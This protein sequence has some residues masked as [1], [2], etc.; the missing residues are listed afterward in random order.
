M[1]ILVVA[2]ASGGH[3]FP[4]LSFLEELKDKDKD[5]RLLLVLP[6][7]NAAGR[8][9]DYGY[10]V[11]YI[12]ISAVKPQI[13]LRNL[14][15]IWGLFKGALESIFLLRG[16]SPDLVVG[17]GS[18]VSV[19][20]VLFARIFGIKTLIHE[21]NLLPGRA[22]KFLARFADKIAVSFEK[23]SCYFA[24]YNKK[25]V[26]TGNP[27]RRELES[28]PRIEALRHFGFTDNKFTILV[29]GGSQ[30]SHN[31]N[32]A[33][34]RTVSE[35]TDSL[36]LQIIHLSGPADYDLLK[37]GYKK[38][39]LGIRLFP[40]LKEMPYAYAASDLAISRCGATT[41]AEMIFFKLPA[42]LIPYPFAYR[43]QLDN[44]NVLV[45]KG[46]AVLIKDGVL[47]TGVLKSTLEGIIN[48][49]ARLKAMRSGYNGFFRSN[50]AS[51]LAQEALSL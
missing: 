7:K 34:L 33:F 14:G 49:P 16:F 22:N 18:V 30:G 20:L 19:P 44:A 27:I 28:C 9:E 25:T 3:I 15:A 46:C 5:A 10:D 51:L 26:V 11:R 35:I 37:D 13:S 42:I 17:F 40:F 2:G 23:T 6:R 50:A 8:I 4:A 39:S 43:H 48:D 1:R 31:I 21:Q 24:G 47:D 32:T 29:M 12:S 41:I 36:R 45:E 38:I